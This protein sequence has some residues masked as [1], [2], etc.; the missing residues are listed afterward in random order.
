MKP[1]IL[2]KPIKATRPKR[3][4]LESRKTCYKGHRMSEDN[5]FRYQGGTWCRKCRAASRIKSR[6]AAIARQKAI[7]AARR[8]EAATAL[9]GAFARKG[10]A[11]PKVK[12]RGKVAPKV[13]ASPETPLFSYKDAKQ[14]SFNAKR[15]AAKR[16]AR[17]AA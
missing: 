4:T 5:K 9:N 17:K 14:A 8:K 7:I 10:K 16:A 15:T 1:K 13:K 11:T 6:P 12:A 3:L 2:P